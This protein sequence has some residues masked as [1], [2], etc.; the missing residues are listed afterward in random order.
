MSLGVPGKSPLIL[1]EGSEVD[2]GNKKITPN[3][4]V[5]KNSGV[6]PPKMDGFFSWKN[7]MG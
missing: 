6:K 4:D 3:I 2:D 1:F 7:P 5:S